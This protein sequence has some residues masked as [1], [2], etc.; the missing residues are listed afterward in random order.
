MYYPYV[1]INY[2]KRCKRVPQGIYFDIANCNVVLLTS[3]VESRRLECIHEDL[4]EFFFKLYS[5]NFSMNHYG[6]GTASILE[7]QWFKNQLIVHPSRSFDGVTVDLS[8][9]NIGAI[10]EICKPKLNQTPFEDWGRCQIY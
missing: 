3:E 10:K 9:D 6:D 1:V 2:Q 8:M 7:Y 5:T 4:L